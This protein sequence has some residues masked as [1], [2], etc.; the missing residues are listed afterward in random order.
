MPRHI[1]QIRR[2]LKPELD[3]ILLKDGELGLTSDTGEVWVGSSGQNILLGRALV[4]VRAL[5]PDPG[6]PGRIYEATDEKTTYIDIGSTWKSVGISSMDLISDGSNYGRV[7]LTELSGGKI[8]QMVSV[9]TGT[10]VTGDAL[11]VHLLNTSKHREIND[12]EINTTNLWSSQKIDT[13]KTDKIVPTLQGNI[14]TLSELGNLQDSG[15]RKDDTGLGTQDI[16]SANKIANE[17]NA[18]ASGLAWQEPALT[19]IISDE[20]FSGSSPSSPTVGDAY[21]VSNWGVL[22]TDGEIR[23]WN[24]VIWKLIATLESGTRVLVK[25]ANAGGSFAGQENTIGDFVDGVWNFTDPVDGNAMLIVGDDSL[26]EHNGYVYATD[27]WIQFTGAG[28]INAGIGLVKSGNTLDINLGAGISELPTD[29]V[30][31]DLQPNQGL[32]LTS[33]ESDGQLA[34]DYDDA[35]LGIV[36]DQLA[37]KD[38]G[39]KP[40][41]LSMLIAGLGLLGGDGTALSVDVGLGLEIIGNQILAKLKSS[42]ALSVNANG[43]GVVVDGT[44]IIIDNNTLK[45]GIIDGGTFDE[46]VQ[47]TWYSTT[48][49]GSYWEPSTNAAWNEVYFYNVT[50]TS[51]Y[52]IRAINS[53]NVSFAPTKMRITYT[54]ATINTIRVRDTD[55]NVLQ[56][57]TGPISSGQTVEL[58]SYAVDMWELLI[59]VTEEN[60]LYNVEFNQEPSI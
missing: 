3:Q 53:W 11:N 32:K 4:G 56:I 49:N 9:A 28:Q 10:A 50:P 14:A 60:N 25:A 58:D 35:T 33:L 12:A 1:I 6:H 7:R 42:G 45:L 34:V 52:V 38:R 18:K 19:F 20:D 47:T 2:G 44:E 51:G 40:A 17:I 31:L 48:P 54:G 13:S 27:S 30:G 21:V 29:E 41:Q 55:N 57:I 37:V 23:E 5:R 8:K 26:Y 46:L 16:W 24:G 15:L 59:E 22:Y 36:G 39:I 43:I